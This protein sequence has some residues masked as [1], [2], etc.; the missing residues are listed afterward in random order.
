[1][2]GNFSFFLLSPA[3]FF[4]INFFIKFIQKTS[5]ECHGLDPDKDQPSVGPDLGPKCLQRL[6][7]EQGKSSM[8][9]HQLPY[10][11][12]LCSYN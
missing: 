6:S 7:A 9:S 11:Q 8:C 1:M 12:K 4:K 10:C 3:D 5:S 2:L